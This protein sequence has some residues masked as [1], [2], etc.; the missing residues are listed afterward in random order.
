MAVNVP[1]DRSVTGAGSQRY[2]DWRAE[3]IDG[4]FASDDDVEEEEVEADEDDDDDED[5]EGSDEKGEMFGDCT[6][7]LLLVMLLILLLPCLELG[8]ECLKL[9]GR[10]EGVLGG[11]PGRVFDVDD[12]DDEDDDDDDEDDGVEVEDEEE[13]EAAGEGDAPINAFVVENVGV[14][15]GVGREEDGVDDA[16]GICLCGGR[17]D[18]RAAEET[19]LAA[20]HA[21]ASAALEA[22][23]VD[24]TTVAEIA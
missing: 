21:L 24:A 13:E 5:D 9:A 20:T 8:V 14:K 10:N 11:M 1:R 19:V 17:P 7:A 15:E 3:A 2:H 4:A 12:D 6:V 18:T 23:G 16:I 22:G